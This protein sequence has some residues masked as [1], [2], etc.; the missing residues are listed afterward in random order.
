MSEKKVRET[1]GSQMGRAGESLFILVSAQ[2]VN[3]ERGSPQSGASRGEAALSGVISSE[4]DELRWQAD[5]ADRRPD[6]RGNHSGC[7]REI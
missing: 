4:I 7:C 3:Q 1:D 6:R 2:L 5:L